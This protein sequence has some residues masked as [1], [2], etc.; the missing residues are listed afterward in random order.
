MFDLRMTPETVNLL[1]CHMLFV[2]ELGIGISFRLVHMAEVAF[3]YRRDAIPSRD[4]NVAYIAFVTC[5]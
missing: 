2:N 1:L 4:L 3:I 5:L